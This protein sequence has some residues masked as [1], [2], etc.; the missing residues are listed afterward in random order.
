MSLVPS[1][2][3]STAMASPAPPQPLQADPDN[4]SLSMTGLLSPE[5]EDMNSFLEEME[6]DLTEPYTSA[7]RAAGYPT[8]PNMPSSHGA[9][10]PVTALGYNTIPEQASAGVKPP[11][12]GPEI[13]S[14]RTRASVQA[15]V[16][17][18]F[19]NPNTQPS[20]P[21]S[22][23]GPANSSGPYSHRKQEPPLAPKPAWDEAQKKYIKS[24]TATHE[25]KR[26]K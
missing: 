25:C 2:S 23:Y 20:L 24:Q 12:A 7:S 26:N 4:S 1:T 9:N 8:S 16:Q 13:L 19:A 14:A 21:K 10:P 17:V 15:M 6:R 3:T 11:L 22:E 18:A 5:M